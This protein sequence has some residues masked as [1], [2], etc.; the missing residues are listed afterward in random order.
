MKRKTKRWLIV[1]F[2]FLLIGCIVFGGIMTMFGWDFKKLVT[3]EYETNTYELENGYQG[4]LIKT[5]TADITVLPSGEG[6]TLV[7]CYEPAQAKHKV[8]VENGLLSVIL[9]DERKW[10]DSIG[11]NLETPKVTLYL[12]E[13]TYDKFLIDSS[14]GR[15]EIS[16]EFTVHTLDI[17]QTTGDTVCYANVLDTL[18]AKTSTGD[19]CI[20]NATA[21]TVSLSVTTGMV[22]ASSLKGNGDV[23]IQVKTGKAS[24]KD[25]SCNSFTTK[26][27]TGGLELINV[28]TTKELWIE[29]STGDVTL[30]D[31]DAGE[32]YMKTSTGNIHGTLLT[33]KVFLVDVDTGK[34]D[35]PKTI[36]G[37]KCEI[38]S[39]T[40]SVK[41]AIA[42]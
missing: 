10:Y 13:K 11:I 36:T 4:I 32:M 22:T 40:G 7:V 12:P 16:K 2:C 38:V 1:A 19:V 8:L 5:K 34:V 39:G 21:K 35:V 14:T 23:S 26:G 30:N 20:E 17:N 15:V 33:P 25:V 24:L 9:E 28:F 37:G 41:I 31:C 3:T 42:E 27:T 6:K 29:R 18:N